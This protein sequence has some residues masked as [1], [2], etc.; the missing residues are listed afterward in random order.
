MASRLLTFWVWALVAASGLFWGFKL[1]ARAPALPAQ[2][3]AAAWAAPMGGSLNRVLGQVAQAEEE[4]GPAG[5]DRFHLLGLVAPAGQGAG[6]ALISVDGQP[7]KP[8]R[9][10]AAVDGDL[11]LLSVG[12]RTARLG[13]A[14]GP[15]TTELTLPEP[16]RAAGGAPVPTVRPGLGAGPAVRLPSPAAPAE[17]PPQGAGNGGG[18][19]D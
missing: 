12:K 4:E 14:G 5:D 19:D 6:V 7:A 16:V 17:A 3:Q 11:V 9:T 1:F 18:D 13:P 15:A 10:G 8:W 2:A